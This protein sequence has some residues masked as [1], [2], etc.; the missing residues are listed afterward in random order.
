MKA[1]SLLIGVL[2]GAGLPSF[3]RKCGGRRYSIGLVMHGDLRFKRCG[4]RG[5]SVTHRQQLV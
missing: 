2:L 4:R 3:R 1:K 5:N